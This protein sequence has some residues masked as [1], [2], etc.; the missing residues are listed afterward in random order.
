[1]KTALIWDKNHMLHNL[2]MQKYTFENE[3]GMDSGLFFE[4][5]ERINL[6]YKLLEKTDLLKEMRVFTP[7]KATDEDI[8]KVHSKKLLENVKSHENRTQP[9]EVGEAAL[10]SGNSYKAALLSAGGALKAIDVLFEEN[11]VKQSYALIRPPGHHATYESPMGFCIFNN[12]AVAARHAQD[13]YGAKKIIII[14]WDVHHGNGTQDIF[15]ND[16]SVFFASIH[17]DKNYPLYGGEIDEIGVKSGKGYNLNVPIVPGC[18]DD[19][20]LRIIDE[21]IK[22]AVK[23]F[24]PDLILVSAGQDP[25]IHDPLSRM[26]VTRNGFK[27]MM[28]KIKELAE[29]ICESRLAV[30]QEGGYSLPYFPIATL[31]VIEGL[32]DI[33]V[34]W[35]A[36]LE[37]LLPYNSF[38]PNIDCIVKN[39]KEK[40]PIIYNNGID[41]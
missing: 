30:F 21:I 4:N 32:L 18:G 12:I 9:I 40:F 22:P 25:N 38:H 17:Q 24:Q 20:Y 29:E 1:M 41:K 35:K 36:D 15:Y 16:D 28:K 27:L 11:E 5:P 6:V 33:E 8:L 2:G 23:W 39:I 26:M 19:E 14:D 13:K 31:G 37:K 34:E 3:L 10:M 7:H